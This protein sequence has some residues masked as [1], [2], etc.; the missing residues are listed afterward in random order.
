MSLSHKSKNI[1]I[2]SIYSNFVIVLLIKTNA[3]ILI[4]LFSI[5]I[6]NSKHR[7]SSVSVLFYLNM[8]SI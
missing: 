7:R 6:F 5:M 3:S 2:F 1:V 4:Y 8:L